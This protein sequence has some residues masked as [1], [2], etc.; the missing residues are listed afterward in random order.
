M[1]GG[2]PPHG[3]A[4]DSF[5]T[6]CA[7][8]DAVEQTDSAIDG[9]NASVAFLIR[10][11]PGGH[12]FRGFEADLDATRPDLH[13]IWSRLEV[14]P[15]AQLEPP[16]WNIVVRDLRPIQRR[17]GQVRVTLETQASLDADPPDPEHSAVR[18]C[19]VPPALRAASGLCHDVVEGERGGA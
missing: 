13:K 7:R 8:L 5:D 9:I 14:P 6:L 10:E 15:R 11:Q 3:P 2:R 1:E 12:G 19:W 16:F 17:A 18:Y 4:R